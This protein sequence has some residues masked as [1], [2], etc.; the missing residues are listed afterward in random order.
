MTWPS[1][2]DEVRAGLLTLKMMAANEIMVGTPTMLLMMPYRMSLKLRRLRDCLSASCPSGSGPSATNSA[3]SGCYKSVFMQTYIPFNQAA[4]LEQARP[5]SI[6]KQHT[7]ITDSKQEISPPRIT[8]WIGQQNRQH[9][10]QTA[11]PS[12][13]DWLPG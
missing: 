9:V 13:N 1:E 10:I 6:L 2:G 7:D 12:C 11:Q 8:G 3:N 5:C 4:H